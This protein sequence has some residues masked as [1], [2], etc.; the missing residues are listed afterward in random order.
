[1]RHTRTERHAEGTLAFNATPLVDV[2][3]LL[4]IFFMLVTRFSSAEQVPMQ[5]PKP[6]ESAAEVV[7]L[8]DR[9]IINCALADPERGRTGGVSY[10][11]GPNRPDSLEVL[12]DRLGAMKAIIPDIKVIVRADRRLSYADVRAVMRVIAGNEIELLNVVAHV[13]EKE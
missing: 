5:L 2:I 10:A 11:I 3:F 8:K 1:M 13:T 9:V 6:E 12:S 7:K 4:T